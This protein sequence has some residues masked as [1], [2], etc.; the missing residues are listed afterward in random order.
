VRA[1]F[2]FDNGGTAIAAATR[3]GSIESSRHARIYNNTFFNNKS[4]FVYR[5]Y[6]NTLPFN[7]N[8][9]K[10]NLVA[11]PTSGTQAILNISTSATINSNA[12]N[13]MNETLIAGNIFEPAPDGN[14]NFKVFFDRSPVTEELSWYEQ[15]YSGNVH[16]NRIAAIR[17]NNVSARS[18]A[19]FQVPSGSPAIDS[20]VALT[21]TVGSG[22]GTVVRV[23]DARYF[24][25]GF[26]IP[27]ETGDM[28]I[29]GTQSPVQIVAI[30]YARNELELARAIQW[31]GNAPVNLQYAGNGPDV[32]AHEIYSA[33]E[34]VAY[35][36]DPSVSQAPPLPPMLISV[37]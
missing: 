3:V 29:I 2:F 30:D 33:G 5:D 24:F 25:D 37:N 16:N 26:N 20:G 22:N 21:R 36:A 15:Q 13:D 28:I 18:P 14:V 27:G 23:Q 32:G 10:N 19:G 31:S 7:N 8:V 35:T 17:F 4:L 9:W 12:A 1:N 11:G 6:G 34:N